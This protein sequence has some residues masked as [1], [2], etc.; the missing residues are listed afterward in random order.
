VSSKYSLQ[1]CLEFAEHLHRAGRGITNPGG[2][3]L[4]IYRSG[5]ADAL[6][7]KYLTEKEGIVAA[8]HPAAG[9]AR[10]TQEQIAEHSS[11]IRELLDAGYTPERVDE[12]FARSFHA[13]DWELIKAASMPVL[14]QDIEGH[15]IQLQ[16]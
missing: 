12:Q 6:V 4:S 13:E 5:V 9:D 1:L 10:L 3:A 7:E 11:L 15:T 14:T 2:Y 16:V 8:D